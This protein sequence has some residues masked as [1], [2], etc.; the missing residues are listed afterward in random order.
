MQIYYLHYFQANCDR[1]NSISDL[2][3]YRATT[4]K[5]AILNNC[6]R[7]FNL[8]RAVDDLKFWLLRVAAVGVALRCFAS[9]LNAPLSSIGNCQLSTI[10]Q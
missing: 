1:K 5:Q 2:V 8:S 4:Y 6:S 10:I 3:S 7:R 9:S